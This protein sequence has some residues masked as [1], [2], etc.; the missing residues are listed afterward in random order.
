MK[1]HSKYL[2]IYMVTMEWLLLI[3]LYT[4]LPNQLSLS[5][6]LSSFLAIKE[7]HILFILGFMLVSATFFL[8]VNF[9]LKYQIATPT[10]LFNISLLFL[11]IALF[12]PY[13]TSWGYPLHAL[14][15]VMFSAFF[16]L[17]IFYMGIKSSD[18]TVKIINF[19]LT[20]LV[21]IIVLFLFLTVGRNDILIYEASIGLIGQ[22]WIII[23]SIYSIKIDRQ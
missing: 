12:A 5:A 6:A 19:S 7:T 21:L 18:K 13:T 2:G 8:F 17:G 14:G 9:H 1:K 20:S 3:F 16:Y 15:A 10:E 4:K 23:I 22:I 11:V